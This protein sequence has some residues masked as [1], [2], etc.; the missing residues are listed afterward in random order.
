M[1]A[2]L[3]HR[4]PSISKPQGDILFVLHRLL[5]TNTDSR[6][7]WVD[8]TTFYV[9][10]GSALVEELNKVGFTLKR[11]SS[12]FGN[13]RHYGFVAQSVVVDNQSTKI[14]RPDSDSVYF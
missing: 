12:L 1:V 8:D 2:G 6:Y 4:R 10:D 9:R 3:S 11:I 5:T 7:G 14:Y 13:L